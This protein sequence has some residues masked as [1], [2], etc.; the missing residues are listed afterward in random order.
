LKHATNILPESQAFLLTAPVPLDSILS[1]AGRIRTKEKCPKCGGKFQGKSLTCPSCLTTPKRFFIDH[2]VKGYGRLKI[3]SDH[4]GR[5]LCSFAHAD[6][7]LVGIRY[8]IDQHIFDP[9]KYSKADLKN[10]LFE[11]RIKAWYESKIKEVEKGNLANS[12]TRCL[13]RYKDSNYIPF[14]KT[15]DVREI[16]TYHIQQFYEQLPEK[17]LK[18]TKNVMDAL[19]NFFKILRNHDFVSDMPTFPVITLDRKTPRWIDRATQVEILKSIPEGDRPIFTFLAFQGVRPGEARALKVKDLSFKE[20]TLIVSRTFSDRIIR[21][22]VK[23]KVSRPRAINPLLLP[24]LKDQCKN[25]HPEAYVFVNPRTNGTYTQNIIN[26]LWNDA[27][28]QAGIDVSLY[29]ATRHSLASNL[30][31]DGAALKSISDILGHTDIRTTLKYAHGD[32]ENQRIAFGRQGQVKGEVI[33]L[34]PQGVPEEKESEKSNNKS[35]R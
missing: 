1:M 16:R 26:E 31:K 17:S 8:E 13:K 10:F 5:P 14:F 25:K 6:R 23:G 21:E 18:S 24:M 28:T 9:T 11:T 30:L 29:Q 34:C 4:Q 35:R 19:R 27:R 2:Y 12:Y 3:Y 15:M 20:E 22:R 33:G 32:L 7:V